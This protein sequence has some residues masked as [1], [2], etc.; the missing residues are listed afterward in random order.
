[1]ELIDHRQ[2]IRDLK[3]APDGSMRLASASRDGTIK[4][5]DLHED[6]NMYK[7]LR[8]KSKWVYACVW[9]PDAQMLVSVGN[10]RSV[11]TAKKLTPGEWDYMHMALLRAICHMHFLARYQFSTNLNQYNNR[12]KV[13]LDLYL[14]LQRFRG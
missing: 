8:G 4:L 6:G 3:F 11:S 5:W 9:S 10:N 7:T 1:M 14:N 12:K 2:V 13:F